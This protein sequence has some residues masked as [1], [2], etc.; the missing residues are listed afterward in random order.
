M[1]RVVIDGQTTKDS[2]R[3]TF[4]DPGDISLS[5][6]GSQTWKYKYAFAAATPATYIP[7]VGHFVGGADVDSKTLT[8]LFNASGVVLKHDW[9]TG[10]SRVQ[11][12]G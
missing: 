6:D 12:G 1:N 9:L 3:K 7:I 10:R 4:G 8:I 2:V 11:R 5:A